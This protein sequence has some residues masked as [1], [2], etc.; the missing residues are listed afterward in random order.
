VTDPII[1]KTIRETAQLRSGGAGGG[2]HEVLATYYGTT[3]EERFAICRDG[4]LVADHY[5]ANLEIERIRLPHEVKADLAARKLVLVLQGGE[6]VDL[7]VEG[8]RGTFLDIFPIFA[9][10]RRRVLQAHRF[11][12]KGH[13]TRR[14]T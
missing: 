8:A 5:I 4:V 11:A 1:A 3:G 14:Q 7:P 12:D 13:P 9:F 6:L 2:E 10:L